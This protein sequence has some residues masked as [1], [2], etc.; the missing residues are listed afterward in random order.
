MQRRNSFSGGYSGAILTL[1]FIAILFIICQSIFQAAALAASPNE[2]AIVRLHWT[3]PGDDGNSGRASIYDIRYSLDSITEENW[4][5]AIQVANEPVPRSAGLSETFIV[6]GLELDSQYYFA[7]KSADDAYN[8]SEI[9]NIASAIANNSYICG[10]VN[11]DSRVSISDAITVINHVFM[12]GVILVPIQAGDANCDSVVN[13]S[14]AIYLI[15]YIFNGASP[16][17]DL[18]QD[19]QPDCW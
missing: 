4:A 8:W 11:G 19:G 1:I 6:T 13:V 17:C 15:N 5:S 10:D 16:P 12:G 7:I 14:D 2:I 18:D 3:S 9:S